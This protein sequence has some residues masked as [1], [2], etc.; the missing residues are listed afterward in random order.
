MFSCQKDILWS[1]L[2][3]LKY[4]PFYSRVTSFFLSAA[5]LPPSDIAEWMELQ[6]S[7]TLLKSFVHTSAHWWA[8]CWKVLCTLVHTAEHTAE[9]FCARA[10]AQNCARVGVKDRVGRVSE[11]FLKF[12]GSGIEEHLP[13]RQ[14]P[15]ASILYFHWFLLTSLVSSPFA[16]GALMPT[17]LD[18]FQATQ[19][20]VAKEFYTDFIFCFSGQ[21]MHLIFLCRAAIKPADFG[22]TIL[23]VM[24]GW[25]KTA[26]K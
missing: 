7:S 20:Q 18:A 6:L 16:I 9:K 5:Q 25:M 13:P 21:C 19:K 12:L 11:R 4:F 10:H 3:S 23:K 24:N 2:V 26:I 14:H 22:T 8:Q 17:I 15:C 1:V